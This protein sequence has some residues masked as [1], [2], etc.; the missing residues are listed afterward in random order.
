MEK[1]NSFTPKGKL[2]AS[3]PPAP[4][5]D[6]T[7]HVSGLEHVY[8]TSGK[9]SDTARYVEVVTK[10]KEQVAVDFWDQGTV[11]ARTMEELKTPVFL[12]LLCSVRMYLTDKD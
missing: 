3:V 9:V 6:F 8:F 5:K 1:R 4:K 12:K 7:A 2:N 11:A 10:L